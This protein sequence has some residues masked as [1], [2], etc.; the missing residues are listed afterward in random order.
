MTKEISNKCWD[1]IKE[2]ASSYQLSAR[3]EKSE[4]EKKK[5]ALMMLASIKEELSK[6]INLD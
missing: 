1:T 2:I 4:E 5:D 6:S 3:T